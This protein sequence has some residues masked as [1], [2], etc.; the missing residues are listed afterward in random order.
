MTLCKPYTVFLASLTVL[1]LL[2]GCAQKTVQIQAE[3]LAPIKTIVVL[4]VEISMDGQSNRP[5]KEMQQLEKGQILL[6]TMLAE[7]FSNREDIALLTPGQR[8]A[9]EKDMAR[10]RTSAVV[11]ICKTKVADAVLL[12]T[13][14]RFTEREGSEYSIVSPASV[15]FTYKLIQAETG[16]T[17]CSGAFD[18]TQQPLL[19][20]MFQFF[21]KAKRGVKWLSA[22]QLAREGF[23]QKIADCPYLKK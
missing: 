22:E 18:E 10:C 9:L 11:T 15:S 1:T 5:A 14:Q 20:D 16:K 17:L 4:P 7:Y 23:K 8:D 13:L 6:D 19:A 12:C 2:S 3:E 21:K